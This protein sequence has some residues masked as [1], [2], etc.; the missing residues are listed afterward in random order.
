MTSWWR[1]DGYTEK[2]EYKQVFTNENTGNGNVV[3]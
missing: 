3:D 1:R 2:Y